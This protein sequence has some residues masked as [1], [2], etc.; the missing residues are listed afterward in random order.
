MLKY[1]L[2]FLIVIYGWY[3]QTFLKI[4]IQNNKWYMYILS[5]LL[6]WVVGLIY[7]GFD[8]CDISSIKYYKVKTWKKKKIPEYSLLPI[9]IRNHIISA[10]IYNLYISYTNKGLQNNDEIPLLYLFFQIG[11]FF[12]IFDI[13][14]YIG[15]RLIHHNKLYPYI[16]KTHHN[17]H[18]DIAISGYYMDIIDFIIEFML[19]VYITTYIL[20]LNIIVFFLSILIGQLNGLI[21]HSGYNFPFIPYEKDH[22][23]HHLELN[24][25]Y[26]IL[27]MDYLFNTKKCNS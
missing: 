23:Y 18:A 12:S 19:P 10:L 15:H 3:M 5:E 27:F 7:L 16:H 4:Q 13:I 9:V 22:L 2:Y 20:D 24:H 21:T 17:T 25:N 6:Y 26:G 14:F 1:S 8:N 11:I